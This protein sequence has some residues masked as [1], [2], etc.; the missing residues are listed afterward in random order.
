MNS[1]SFGFILSFFSH[2]FP[3]GKSLFLLLNPQTYGVFWDFPPNLTIFIA[4]SPPPSP[5][6]RVRKPPSVPPVR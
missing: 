3:S 4:G 1:A 5:G 6:S 2:I